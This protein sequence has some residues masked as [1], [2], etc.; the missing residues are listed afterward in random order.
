MKSP[1][2]LIL[3]YMLVRQIVLLLQG[4]TCG[5]ALPVCVPSALS[6]AWLLSLG[7]GG[8]GY[9]DCS[10][11]HVEQ[12]V[13]ARLTLPNRAALH[14]TD[15]V[16]HQREKAVGTWTTMGE[17]NALEVSAGGKV[18]SAD[19]T[20]TCNSTH[21]GEWRDTDSELFGCFRAQRQTIAECASFDDC[22]NS[23]GVPDGRATTS[24]RLRGHK[25]LSG[26]TTLLPNG[27]A[28]QAEGAVADGASSPPVVPLTRHLAAPASII[29]RAINDGTGLWR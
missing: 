24:L 16:G 21:W 12:T 26:S 18:F 2:S 9:P 28:A 10:T 23:V 6:G 25:P 5:S 13:A 11:P 15:A 8:P 3:I 1:F 4:A 7:P 14:E 27:R 29:A 20:R 17:A 22:H 19:F